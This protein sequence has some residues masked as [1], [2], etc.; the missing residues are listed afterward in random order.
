MKS[1]AI[2]KFSLVFLLAAFSMFANA[3]MRYDRNVSFDQFPQRLKDHIAAQPNWEDG[4]LDVTKPPY[5]AQGDGITDD[6]EALQNAIDDAFAANLVV[7]FPSGIYM[8]SNQLRCIQPQG[9]SLPI[10]IEAQSQ[11]KFG[12]LLLGSNSV[13]PTIRLIDNSSV[14]ENVLIKFAYIADSGTEDASR[15]YLGSIRNFNIDMGNNPDV[16]AVYNSGAQYSVI[17]NLNIF[18]NFDAGIY[19]IPGSGGYTANIS[20]TGGKVGIRQD[21][22]RPCPTIFGLKLT[23]QTKYGIELLNTRGALT[24]AGFEIT[25]PPD[26]EN[27]YAAIYLSNAS[28][29]LEQ[30][31]VADLILKDGTIQTFSTAIAIRNDDQNV[32]LQNVWMKTDEIISSGQGPGQRVLKGDKEAWK[33]VEEYTYAAAVDQ[34]I[35][36]IGG[37]VLPHT[38]S[39]IVHATALIDSLPAD[40]LLDV[41]L[42]GDMPSWEDLHVNLVDDFGVTRDDDKDDDAITIQRAIDA[43][44]T[45][46]NTHYGKTL[47]IPRGYYHLR[48]SVILKNG[49]KMVGAGKNISVITAAKDWLPDLPVSIVASE[50]GDD[51]SLKLSDFALLLYNGSV[52]SATQNRKNFTLLDIKAGNTTIRDIQ[53]DIENLNWDY[54]SFSSPVICFSENAGGNVYGLCADHGTKGAV[55]DSYRMV[56]IRNTQNRLTF[57]QISVED[58]QEHTTAEE[59]NENLVQFEV[60]NCSQVSI[61]GFK[62][63]GRSQLCSVSNTETFCV[64][65]GA[66][67]YWFEDQKKEAVFTFSKVKNILIAN[68]SHDPKVKLDGKGFFKVEGQLINQDYPIIFLKN[69]NDVVQSLKRLSNQTKVEIYPNPVKSTLQIRTDN[70]LNVSRNYSVHNIH[71][72]AIQNGII[73]ENVIDCS[74]L[75]PGI[76]MLCVSIS[77]MKTCMQFLKK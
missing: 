43:V 56:A 9:R 28:K 19:R 39:G 1:N 74:S 13:W 66:G 35:V 76:Y 57:Y 31:A 59:E 46:G 18:G 51:T 17:Q 7:Y 26:S 8:V 4:F 50:N 64:Y 5:T 65:G 71:G 45:P 3:K 25:G 58:V 37:V 22:Y 15:H 16:S 41:H 77:G 69:G 48:S 23:G 21:E 53:T 62:Y 11:R 44:C 60:D 34:G 2:I 52:K 10:P 47:F 6:T 24:V 27:D 33:Y 67:N 63:E 54:N 49:L 68:L 32:V 70:N 20:I 29:S 12:H 42:W 73:R 75:N 72:V 30:G 61:Y 14:N 40:N 38:G 55:D 36:S